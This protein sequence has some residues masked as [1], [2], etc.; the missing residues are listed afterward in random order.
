[1]K[2][3]RASWIGGWL[4]AAGLLVHSAA[5]LAQARPRV[6]F[7]GLHVRQQAPLVA[8][9]IERLR[10]LGYEDGR[11]IVLDLRDADGHFERLP[12]LAADIVASRPTI[13]V[14]AS[15]PAV[16]AVQQAT[17]SVPTVVLV[18]DPVGSG[19]VQSLARPGG[20]ITGVAFQDSDLSA[21]RLDLLRQMV[22]HLSRVAVIWNRE[23]GGIHSVQAVEA[24]GRAAGLAI[25]AFE[26]A[27]PADLPDAVAAARAWGAQGVVQLA[28]PVITF[29]RTLLIEAANRHRLPLMCEMRSYV[30]DGCLATYSASLS[31]MF[32]QLADYVD[33]VLRGAR[34]ETLPIE[35][36]REFEFVIN[37]ATADAIGV[38]LGPK[39]RLQAQDIILR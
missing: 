8:A 21:K 22:P 11:T 7:L 35:Q 39:I 30:V 37:Q 31:A 19:F 25:R 3:H 23:G 9:F 26:I 16:R 33:R 14:T 5:A 27:Q 15:P 32:A 17:T 2:P 12:Q 24:A 38:T 29:N 10:V 34:A 36:P 18:H 6:A 1:M 13:I 20:N 4:L 28:S